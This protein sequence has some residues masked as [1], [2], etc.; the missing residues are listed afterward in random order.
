M[1]NSSL[2]RPCIE[3]PQM[4]AR[5]LNRWMPAP[6]GVSLPCFLLVQM[7]RV[8]LPAFFLASVPLAAC[9]AGADEQWVTVGHAGNPPDRTGFGA[10][11]DEFQIMKYEVT[12]SQYADFLNA[13]ADD[14]DPHE[15]W[16]RAMGEHVITDLGQGGIRKDVPQCILREVSDGH[17]TYSAV[18]DWENRPVIFVTCFSAMRYANWIHNGRGAG[19]TEDGVYRLANGRDVK[20][21]PHAS[22]WLPSEDEWYKAAYYQCESEG[23]PPGDYWPFP[24]STSERPAKADPGSTLPNAAAFSRR[25]NGILPVGSYPNAKSP[26]GALDMGGNVW[27]WTEDAIFE[28]K[29]VLRGGAAAHTWEKL[30][31]TV[32]SNARPDRWYPDT[33]FRLA[34][35]VKP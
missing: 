26:C 15:L 6:V 23:G 25:F 28:N 18:P 24:T 11:D 21:S 3:I 12:A 4:K 33:G 30:Q 17:W 34:R 22:V 27:E 7:C 5:Y 1:Q 19:D 35:R 9:T 2:Q 20:R 31:S 13:V 10:V 32:R 16:Q 29:R 8:M 14:E